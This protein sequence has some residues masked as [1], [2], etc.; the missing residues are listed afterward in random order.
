VKRAEIRE[1]LRVL[2]ERHGWRHLP[3]SHEALGFHRGVGVHVME[4]EGLLA[5]LFFAPSANVGDEILEHFQGFTHCAEAGLPPD[6]FS[7]RVE[8]DHSCLLRMDG[9]QLEELDADLFFAIPD[10]VARDFHAHGATEEVLC[11]QCGE[12]PAADIRLVD[13]TYHCLC[14]FCRQLLEVQTVGGQLG[15][16]VVLW[17]KILPRLAWAVPLLAVVWGLL[18]YRALEGAATMTIATVATLAGGLGVG[19]AWLVLSAQSAV[20]LP[21]RLVLCAT[22]AVPVL[23][24]NVWTY[25]VELARRNPGLPLPLGLE[26][27]FTAQL[28][29]HP[30]F[31]L[32]FPVATAAGVWIGLSLFN[33]QRGVRVR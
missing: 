30:S 6:W 11:E 29:Q 5:F 15:R 8:D 10:L 13:R 1:L 19:F 31:E 32:L 21:L 23:A 20:S 33:S 17:H 14:A 27:Y 12:R 28:P 3:S 24:G 7:G 22:A 18:F 25:W 26:L 2:A 4:D 16:Q 9:A